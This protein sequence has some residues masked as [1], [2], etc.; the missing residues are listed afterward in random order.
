MNITAELY[1]MEKYLEQ[2]GV[3]KKSDNDTDQSE[4][5]V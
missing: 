4:D 2:Y 5:T 1:D 3:S